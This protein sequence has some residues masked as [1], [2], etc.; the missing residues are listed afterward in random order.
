[1]AYLAT[2]S[3]YTLLA[4]LGCAPELAEVLL[5]NKGVVLNSVLEDQLAAQVSKDPAI[6]NSI[7]Q[8]HLAE[9]RLTQLQLAVPKHLLEA[10]LTHREMQRETLENQIDIMQKRLARNVSDFN[11]IRR[12]TVGFTQRWHFDGFCPIRTLFGEGK[13]RKT[14]WGCPCRRTDGWI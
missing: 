10:G 13:V 5:R 14:L 6:R 7:D 2:K 3:P 1:M 12:V 8:L 9:L 11:Q 4:T